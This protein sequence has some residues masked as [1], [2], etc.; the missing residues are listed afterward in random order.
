MH[1]RVRLQMARV[2]Q[3]SDEQ[4]L[5]C[6]VYVETAGDD[7]ARE[8]DSVGNSL[9]GFAGATKRWG[10]DPLAAPGV[11]YQTEGQVGGR[12]QAHAQ[13]DCFG[14]IFWLA[15]LRD[16]REEGR[17]GCAGDEDRCRGCDAGCE[18]GITDDSVAEVKV[19]CL[20]GCCWSVSCCYAD[21]G[22][23]ST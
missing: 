17:C 2:A 14:V 1:G 23:I 5:G 20:G 16:D 11:D 22:A 19:A 8:G 6:D 9:D 10:G 13:V 21:A 4:V 7:Q 15:H 12:Y 3:D 18:V